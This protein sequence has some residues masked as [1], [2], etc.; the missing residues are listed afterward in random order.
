MLWI[1]IIIAGIAAASAGFLSYYFSKNKI[2][3]GSITTLAVLIAI[4][5]TYFYISPYYLA[6]RFENNIRSQSQFL[7]LIA[8]QSPYEFNDYVSKVKKNIISRGDPTNEAYYAAE[9]INSLLMKYGPIA[10]DESLYNYL[11][12]D[13]EFDK[14]LFAIDPVLVL[15]QEFPDKF[16]D[17]ID[18]SKYSVNDLKNDMLGAVEKVVE[19][20]I[21]N[22]HPLPTTEDMALAEGVFRGILADLGK[23]YG[24]T[25]LATALQRPE[26]PAVD[27]K[28]AA[29]IIMD[30]SDAIFSKG[31][32]TTGLLLRSSF[33]VNQ[34]NANNPQ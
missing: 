24:Q 17:K 19:S 28:I 25:T 31:E 16:A 27:K 33:L 34:M 32:E 5:F 10:S 20:G 2:L 26:D 9:L 7:D 1:Y 21:K 30:I 15:F 4:A 13:I 22:P 6:W 14:K 29:Q 3:T 12:S 18:L 8:E 23:K 11:R